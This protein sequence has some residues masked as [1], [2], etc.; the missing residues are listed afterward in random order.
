VQLFTNVVA[1]VPIMKSWWMWPPLRYE[2]SWNEIGAK[3]LKGPNLRGRGYVIQFNDAIYS[4]KVSL[5]DYD[6]YCH[7]AWL[8]AYFVFPKR[9]QG[10]FLEQPLL[11][12]TTI[13]YLMIPDELQREK[14]KSLSI[15]RG[16][17]NYANMCV[18]HMQLLKEKGVNVEESLCL[19]KNHE[20]YA[21]GSYPHTLARSLFDL[22]PF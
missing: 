20:D 21:Q 7:Q 4:D 3:G 19:G 11:N 13:D 9:F 15:L 5:V 8:A 6:E 18:N 10:V 1:N 16:P 12:V 2:C 17:N 22:L 14:P